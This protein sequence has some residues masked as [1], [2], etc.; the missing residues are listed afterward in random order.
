[1]ERRHVPGGIGRNAHQKVGD[2]LELFIAVVQRGHDQCD[3]LDPEGHLPG[4]PD[5]IEH[6]LQVPA[7]L[8]VAAL[9]EAFQV[10][11]EQ[12]HVRPEKLE[13]LRRTVAVGDVAAC[14]PVCAGQLEDLD[15]PFRGDQGLVVGADHGRHAVVRGDSHQLLRPAEA[16]VADRLIVPQGLAGDP[17]LAEAAVEVTPE[18][19]ERERF[20]SRIGV[21]EGLLFD[22]V[23]L[24]AGHV[25][26]WHAELT[27]LIEAD[28][29]DA[30]ATVGD[31]AAMSAGET[32]NGLV[33]LVADQLAR[34]GKRVAVQQFLQRDRS[35]HD[36]SF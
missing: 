29:A 30:R 21:V 25:S 27:V 36:R 6:V 24:Q 3:D 28:A 13:D 26:A 1:M 33:A 31:H 7:K 5:R 9:V 15:R 4:Q 19:P 8:A 12:L 11:L 10:D 20:A 32:L 18:H 16:R 2:S 17:I 34:C 22:R 14:N 23:D 35:G